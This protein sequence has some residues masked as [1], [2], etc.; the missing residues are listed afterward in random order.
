LG[1]CGLHQLLEKLFDFLNSEGCWM[2]YPDRQKRFSA[3]VFDP[4]TGDLT[5]HGMKLRLEQQPK[6]ILR[7]LIWFRAR[8]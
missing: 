5:R 3:C 7:L 4:K 8:R 2:E 1:N 6:A